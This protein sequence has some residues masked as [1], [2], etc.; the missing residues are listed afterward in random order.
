[1]HHVRLLRA[2]LP[3]LLAA[4]LWLLSA[5][6]EWLSDGTTSRV[7]RV[8]DLLA[9]ETV[10]LGHLSAPAPW[11]LLVSASWALAVL[12]AYAALLA[13]VRTRRR[14]APPATT[15]AAYWMCAVVAAAGVAAV[16][17]LDV[18]VRALAAGD[19]PS[20][21]GGLYLVT[22]T[23]W[24]LVWGWAPATLALVLDDAAPAPRWRAAAAG[25]AV[26]VVGAVGV[27]LASGGAD[28]AGAGASA[29]SVRPVEAPPAEV[30]EAAPRL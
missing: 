19:A 17:V 8:L 25:A 4:L 18:V 3:A 24:G 26:L 10:P 12:G 15:F 30:A 9:P 27:V 1:M 20:G 28:A 22:A 14:E 11:G 29:G 6:L 5:G 23:H 21:V 16:P 7:L 2:W 13:V